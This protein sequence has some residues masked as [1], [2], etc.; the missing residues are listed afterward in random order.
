MLTL[1][2]T[3]LPA[4][5]AGAS[6]ITVTSRGKF[7]GVIAATARTGSEV[8]WGAQA[9]S[10]GLTVFLAGAGME[11]LEELHVEEWGSSTA[12]RGG[13]SG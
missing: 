5:S 8:S 6:F 10:L 7:Q 13:S 12:G 3:A 11:E 9:V 4:V 2:T 1:S